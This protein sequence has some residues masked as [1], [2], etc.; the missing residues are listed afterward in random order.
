MLRQTRLSMLSS[1]QYVRNLVLLLSL[2]VCSS[3]FSQSATTFPMADG[4]RARYNV[5]IDFRKAYISGLCIMLHEDGVVKSSI[6]NEFGVSALDFTYHPVSHKVKIISVMGKLN[7]WYIKRQLKRN[8]KQV[9]TR[10]PMGMNVYED[11]KYG[12]KYTFLPFDETKDES[13]HNNDEQ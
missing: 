3:A 13:I 5:Q 2:A 4:D 10:L 12:I 8:L 11:T 6:V 9:M 7:K 1:L